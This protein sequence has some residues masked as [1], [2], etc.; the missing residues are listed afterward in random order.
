MDCRNK[1]ER[2]GI[3]IGY[4]AYVPGSTCACYT[5]CEYDGRYLDHFSFEIRRPNCVTAEVGAGKGSK[6]IPM[7]TGYQC[8]KLA[9][10]TNWMDGHTW[11]DKFSIDQT[12]NNIT[13][14][15]TDSEDGWVKKS[16]F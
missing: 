2:L 13:V 6:V 8:P 16:S 14:T 12:A 15:R 5:K 11:P 4:F 7:E 3:H 10:I 1:C 9:N